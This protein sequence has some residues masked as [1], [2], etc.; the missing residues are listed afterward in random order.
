MLAR[1][2][3]NAILCTT[4]PGIRKINHAK[5]DQTICPLPQNYNPKYVR[6]NPTIR[7]PMPGIQTFFI[8]RRL[9]QSVTTIDGNVRAGHEARG[10]GGK[11]DS[12]TIEIVDSAEAGLWGQ[13]LPDLLLCVKGGDVVEGSVHVSCNIV[14]IRNLKQRRKDR[15]GEI[16]LTRI[17]YLAHSA[18]SDLP[19]WM[20]PAL[21]A[22]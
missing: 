15:P 4:R 19:N 8:Y 17:L 1:H 11:E 22:L 3:N 18:A 13:G 20:T 16:Q 12:E 5:T 2:L 9:V 7:L 6:E 14:S 10:I 21:E